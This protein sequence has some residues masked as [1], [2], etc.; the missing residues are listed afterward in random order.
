MFQTPLSVHGVENTGER[1][2]WR[3]LDR[4]IPTIVPSGRPLTRTMLACGM[5]IVRPGSPESNEIET[6]ICFCG[7]QEWLHLR[8]APENGREGEKRA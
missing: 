1:D 8:V 3:R 4:I 6:K 5:D 7:V 2:K